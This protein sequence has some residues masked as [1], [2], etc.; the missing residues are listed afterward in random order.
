M[1]L[2]CSQA[3]RTL[4]EGRALADTRVMQGASGSTC[5]LRCRWSSDCGPALTCSYSKAR[6]QW[7]M[8]VEHAAEAKGVH[9]WLPYRGCMT[10]DELAGF[11][12]TEPWVGGGRAC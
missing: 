4:I 10:S 8:N 6:G 1:K 9:C 5:D 3:V 2:G 12:D 7:C 11:V